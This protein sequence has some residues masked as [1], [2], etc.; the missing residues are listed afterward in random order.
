MTNNPDPLEV[1]ADM[2]KKRDS[3]NYPY[4]CDEEEKITKDLEV[5][6]E[7]VIR[8]QQDRIKELERQK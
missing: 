6:M 8:G 4:Q 2:K 5:F 7:G 1:I 3:L